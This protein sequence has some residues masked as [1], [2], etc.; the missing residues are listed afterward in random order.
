MK[1]TVINI[2]LWVLAFFLTVSTAIYQRKT[3]P[4]HP[5]RGEIEVNG[6]PVKY[7]FLR[8]YDCGYDFPIRLDISGLPSNTTARV[9]WKRYKLEEPFR[10]ETMRPAGTQP[11]EE[12]AQSKHHHKAKATSQ[13]SS[14]DNV[15]EAFLPHQPAAGKLEYEVILTV[16]GENYYLPGS[17]KLVVMRYKGSVPGKVLIPHIFFMFIG[18]MLGWRAFLAVLLK[19][20]FG[21]LTLLTLMFLTIGGLILGPIVQKYAFDAYWTGWPFGEDLTDNK[22]LV[23]VIAWLIAAI[24]AFQPKREKAA[25]FWVITATVL[26]IAVYLIPHS[27][28]GSELDYSELEADST[29]ISAPHPDSLLQPA[30]ELPEKD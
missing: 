29:L 13:V 19:Q 3:G 5:L 30:G 26:T 15:I 4:T 1:K 8:S 11:H 9:A 10:H 23:I 28:M 2:L 27:M 18:M 22:T 17:E 16:D 20:K 7:K 25:R 14:S 21:L 12:P 6:T 24:V